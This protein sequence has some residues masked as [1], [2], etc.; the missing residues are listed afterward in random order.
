[1]AAAAPLQLTLPA[2]DA[3]ISPAR[4]GRIGRRA[5]FGRSA[6]DVIPPGT[7]VA[8]A[9]AAVVDAYERQAALQVCTLAISLINQACRAQSYLWIPCRVSHGSSPGAFYA[10]P[11]STNMTASHVAGSTCVCPNA[12]PGPDLEHAPMTLRNPRSLRR[13]IHKASKDS[14]VNEDT[15]VGAVSHADQLPGAAASDPA[16]PSRQPFGRGV[17]H[18]MLCCRWWGK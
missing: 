15:A 7:A 13:L 18:F 2:A 12:Q 14:P 17:P 5:L 8:A 9:A 6:A 10:Q 4:I 3:E 11:E 1:M 16:L